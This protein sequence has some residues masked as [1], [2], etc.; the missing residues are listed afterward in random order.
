MAYACGDCYAQ[1]RVK[2]V[3]DADVDIVKSILNTD[4]VIEF[5]DEQMEKDLDKSTSKCVICYDFNFTGELKQ[6][7]SKGTFFIAE[8]V[9]YKLKNDSCCVEK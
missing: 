1:Y 2:E 9:D 8:S 5:K 3:L 4:I 7:K 6:S